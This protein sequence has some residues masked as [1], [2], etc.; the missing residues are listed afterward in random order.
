MIWNIK[1]GHYGI[2]TKKTKR[3]TAKAELEKRITYVAGT[4]INLDLDWIRHDL[5]C[6]DFCSKSFYVRRNLQR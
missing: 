6:V 1:G 4:L 3:N 2:Y 5:Y